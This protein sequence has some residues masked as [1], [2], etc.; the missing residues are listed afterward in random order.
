MDLSAAASTPADACS[1]VSCRCIV[2]SAQSR[3]RLGNLLWARNN[4]SDSEMRNNQGFPEMRQI[5]AQ[6]PNLT[7]P[8]NQSA[9][10]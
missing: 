1:P 4:L 9:C 10:R 3:L 6:V 5:F 2:A 7:R 8:E